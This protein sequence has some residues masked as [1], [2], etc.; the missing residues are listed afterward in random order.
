MTEQQKKILP[1]NERSKAMHAVTY[2]RK[3]LR[4]KWSKT[5]RQYR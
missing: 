2:S 3:Y 1:K 5:D 4:G